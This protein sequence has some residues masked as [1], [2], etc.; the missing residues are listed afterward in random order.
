MEDAMHYDKEEAM[1]G[2][3]HAVLKEKSCPYK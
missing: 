3:A 2:S 1:G